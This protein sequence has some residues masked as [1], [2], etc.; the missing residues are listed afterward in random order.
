MSSIYITEKLYN[1]ALGITPW[2]YMGSDQND[3][4]VY[5]GS[6][7]VKFGTGKGG[8]RKKKEKND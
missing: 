2:R 1:K 5:F 7:S 6:R 8:G 3:N 4:P